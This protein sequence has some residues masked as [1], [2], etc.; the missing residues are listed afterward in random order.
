[1]ADENETDV[2]SIIEF[3]EDISSQ[4]APKLLPVAEYEATI[5]GVENTMSQ[6]GRKY[7]AVQFHIDTSQFPAD[8]PVENN[9]DGL[10][11]TYRMVPLED[12]AKSRYQLRKFLEAVNA[13]PAGKR[14]D[15]GEWLGLTAKVGIR[16]G[17]F[18]GMKREEI[19][20]V[21]AL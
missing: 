13:P 3:S 16:H 5:R 12:N 17:E 19:A 7:A 18:E 6:K 1:M 15:T 11:L 14:V 10:T 2:P 9:P 4:E 21:S 8:Y 20:K